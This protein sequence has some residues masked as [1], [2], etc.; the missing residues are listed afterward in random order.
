[1]ERW[2]R[3]NQDI[4][5]NKYISFM[6]LEL[7]CRK[8]GRGRRVGKWKQAMATWREGRKERKKES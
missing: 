6:I 7:Y 1:V 8:T 5:L 4:K 2:N 3:C